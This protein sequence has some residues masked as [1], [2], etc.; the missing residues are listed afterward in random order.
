MSAEQS[1]KHPPTTEPG[2]RTQGRGSGSAECAPAIRYTPAEF[3]FPFILSSTVTFQE[4]VDEDRKE[5]EGQKTS[6]YASEY[7]GYSI[8]GGSGTG[9]G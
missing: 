3:P 8:I 1:R 6:E 7:G 4:V 5:D 9:I 2:F